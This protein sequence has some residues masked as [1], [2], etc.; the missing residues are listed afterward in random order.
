MKLLVPTD[1]S[2]VA[3]YAF[4]M[5][6]MIAKRNAGTVHV[7]HAANIPDDWED[8]T[9][10]DKLRDTV[11]MAIAMDARNKLKEYHQR[12]SDRGIICKTHFN[13]GA[14]VNNISEVMAFIDFDIVV[15]G[16]HGASGKQEWFIGS[17]ATKLL[18]RL[19]IP[20]LVVKNRVD[21]DGF[22]NVVYVTGH[23][24]QDIEGFKKLL[25]FLRPFEIDTLHLLTIK[26]SDSF[27]QPSVMVYEGFQEL[28]ELA[29]SYNC[30]VHFHKA[31][32]IDAG[33]RQFARDNNIDLIVM[34]NPGAN[35][36]RRALFGSNV[37]MVINH[38]DV[39]VLTLKL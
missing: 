37:E 16:S 3:G 39:P 28:T 20:M 19:D 11:N 29:G 24:V 18:R 9:L 21:S 34:N 33:V 26:S 32:S 2:E 38:T 8:L 4:E 13:G 31:S 15:M 23:D 14:L 7:Y 30:D 1:F 6:M 12:A 36:L 17:N 5:A 35:P 25:E 22:K 10:E 27:F